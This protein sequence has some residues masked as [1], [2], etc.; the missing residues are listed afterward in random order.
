M[1]LGFYLR[2]SLYLFGSQWAGLPLEV[3]LVFDFL[4]LYVEKKWD[5]SGPANASRNSHVN[6]SKIFMMVKS[7]RKEK[8]LIVVLMRKSGYAEQ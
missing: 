1:R 2:G 4:L 8:L 7:R 6:V 5:P 3:A